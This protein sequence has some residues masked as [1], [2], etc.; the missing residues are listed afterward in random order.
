MSDIRPENAR[1]ARNRGPILPL[2]YKGL[3]AAQLKY[4]K[5]A[6]R[7]GFIP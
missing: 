3:I 5:S 2:R 4:E 7:L 1:R 6:E